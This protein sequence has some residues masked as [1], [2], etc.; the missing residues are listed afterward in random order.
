MIENGIQILPEKKTIII[1]KQQ[2]NFISFYSYIIE[3]FD[4]FELLPYPIPFEYIDDKPILKKD[5]KV[6]DH[7][8]R[9]VNFNDK[10]VN[11]SGKSTSQD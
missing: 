10:E 11:E 4:S 9:E 1:N 3:Q 6:L 5:W 2:I 8:D 7:L